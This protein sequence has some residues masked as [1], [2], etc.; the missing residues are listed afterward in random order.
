M[1]HTVRVRSAA[2]DHCVRLR[3]DS[4]GPSSQ[5]FAAERWALPLASRAGLNCAR[6]LGT[7]RVEAG[8]GWSAAVFETVEGTRFDHFAFNASGSELSSVALNWG[9]GL[10]RLHALHCNGFGT[11]REIQSRDCVFFLSDLFLKEQAPLSQFEPL[12][13]RRYVDRVRAILATPDLRIRSPCF[14]HGDVHPRNILV[15]A[16]RVVWLDW[17]TCRRRLP[18]FDFAQL[19]FTAWRGRTS[20]RDSMIAAYRAHQ[21]PSTQLSAALL[22]LV[23]L[24]WHIRFGLFLRDCRLPVDTGYFGTFAEHL[25]RAHG[26]ALSPPEDWAE[27]LALGGTAP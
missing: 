12:L 21:A 1:N 14:V 6:L 2:G 17:E 18:E 13:T 11:L 27:A 24:Y 4:L 3:P 8:K 5:L 15:H 16:E 19:P 9:A 20:L 25:D 26:L 23:Q 22:H 10:A 7:T